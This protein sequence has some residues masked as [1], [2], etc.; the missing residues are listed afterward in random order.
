MNI[1][2]LSGNF[3]KVGNSDFMVSGCDS[4]GCTYKLGNVV[5]Y[6]ADQF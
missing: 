4:V 3:L 1:L 5:Y 6:M 2:I